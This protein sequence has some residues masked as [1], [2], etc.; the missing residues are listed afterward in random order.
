MVC[1]VS[2]GTATI[3]YTVAGPSGGTVTFAY[4]VAASPAAISGTSTMCVGTT[5]TFTDPTPG[6]VWT[7]YGAVTISAAGVVTASYSGVGAVDYVT[8]SGGCYT[9]YSVTATS[10]PAVDSIISGPSTVCV[11]F[12]ATLSD[13]TS[14]GVWTSSDPSVAT[15]DPSTGVVTGVSAGY[16]NIDY[17]VTGTCGTTTISSFMTVVS[18]A[19]AGTISGPS[20]VG[21]GSY[22]SLSD[23]VSGGSWSSSDPSVATIS[24]TGVVTGVAAGT[25]TISYTVSGCGTS[26]TTTYTVTVTAYDAITGTIFFPSA[27]FYGDVQVWLI[28]YNSVTGDLEALDSQ[29]VYSYGDSATYTFLNEPTDSFRVKAAVIDSV[30]DSTGYI[31]TY[32]TSSYYWYAADVIAH[33]SGTVN[34]HEDIN[35]QYGAVTSGP[36]FI[37]GNVATGANKGTSGS[38]PVKGLI[39]YCINSSTSQLV[40]YTRTDASGNYHFGNLPVGQT[41]FVFPDSINYTTVPYTGISLTSGTPVM[42]GA[43]FIQHTISKVISPIASAVENVT[44]G[45]G[46]VT[47]FPNPTIGKLFVQWNASAQEDATIIVSDITGRQVLNNVVTLHPGY[48]NAQL[49]LSALSNGTYIVSV[50]S[51]SLN[52]SSKVQV[53]H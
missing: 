9:S 11:G 40:Q 47:V 23:G 34:S 27:P 48:G 39:M 41:Y 4:T 44:A 12:T 35:M 51:A 43:S 50:K 37:G 53:Q 45:T 21:A 5:A 17:A 33:V 1:G 52:Y 28:T 46:A 18:T 25:V 26:T 24:S 42:A 22:I 3:S 14:G 7:A 29:W 2:P 32:H 30:A 6:G 13:L 15:V 38:I 19:S 31:P 16:V 49:D 20:T 8:A 36:G 10:G